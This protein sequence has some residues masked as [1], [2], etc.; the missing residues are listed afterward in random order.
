[1]KAITRNA[2]QCTEATTVGFAQN[3]YRRATV[4]P[5]AGRARVAQPSLADLFRS[6]SPSWG[7]R[8]IAKRSGGARLNV[9]KHGGFER[10]RTNPALL[11]ILAPLETLC[12]PGT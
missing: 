8:L 5:R 12:A 11:G 3:S 10:R 6:A 7:F 2:R 9:E 4:R 1:M